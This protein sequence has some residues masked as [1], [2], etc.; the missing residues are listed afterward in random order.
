MKANNDERM[1]G[2][3]ILDISNLQKWAEKISGQWDGDLPGL[4][5]DKAHCAN[6]IID[7]CKKLKELL[8]EMSSYD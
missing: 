1:L 8:D 3:I 6:D 4:V 2:L 7:T 5:E